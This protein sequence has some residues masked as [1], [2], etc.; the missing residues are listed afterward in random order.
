MEANTSSLNPTPILDSAVRPK[1]RRA[2]LPALLFGLVLGIPFGGL[3]VYVSRQA[4]DA[5][6]PAA[7]F[8]LPIYFVTFAVVIAVH[9]LGHLLAGWSVGFHF[10]SFSVGPFSILREY[11]RLKLKIRRTLPA[12]GYAGMH[13]NRVLRLRRRLLIFTLGGPLANLVSA[14]I[15]AAVLAYVPRTGTWLGTCGELFWM[16]SAFLGLSSLI[17]VRIG[18]L[19]PDGARIWMLLFSAAKARRWLC[20]VAIGSQSHA[21]IRSRDFRRTWLTGA[22]AVHDRS[23]DEFAA[24]WVAY[25]AANDRK[26]APVAAQHLE[27]CLELV[28]LLG[29]T[30]QDTIALEAAV[31]TAWFRK[32][33]ATAQ[34]WLSQVKRFNA[35][36]QLMR[37]RA[38]I[39]LLCA[40]NDF[41]S[42]TARWQNLIAL[43]EKLPP[44]PVRNKLIAGLSEWRAEIEDRSNAVPARTPSLV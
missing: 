40:R 1:V 14:G 29:P 6:S 31:F 43:A 23:V 38:E 13:V 2:K 19:F 33:A 15:T 11:G 35:L 34:K 7:E 37:M 44:T 16:V 12:G 20:V 25:G 10:S 8:V 18:M 22:G 42:A 39:A 26:H 5:D 9:E 36:P 27:I 41:A 32:D 21:G 24:N 30:L 3:L 17:P 4:H 28:G